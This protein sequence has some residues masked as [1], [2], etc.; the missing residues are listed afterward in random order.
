MVILFSGRA[1]S[2][3]LDLNRLSRII[4][5]LVSRKVREEIERS[6]YIPLFKICLEFPARKTII[7]GKSLF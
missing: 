3:A 6:A 4:A 2:I 1:G 5:L 7:L